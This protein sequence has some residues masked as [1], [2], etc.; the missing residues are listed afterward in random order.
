MLRK[1]GG[2][3]SDKRDAPRGIPER[4][5]LFPIFGLNA[6]EK[7]TLLYRLFYSE[8]VHTLP[9]HTFQTETVTVPNHYYCHHPGEEGGDDRKVLKFRLFDV[10]GQTGMISLWP[11]HVDL[12]KAKAAIFVVDSTDR[13]RLAYAKNALWRLF[14][15]YDDT[16]AGKELVFLVGVCE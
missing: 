14:E 4:D 5:Y 13:Q 1:L 7:S 3:L 15:H 16:E 8:H 12:L 2:Y 6:G 9:D 10:A 11:V